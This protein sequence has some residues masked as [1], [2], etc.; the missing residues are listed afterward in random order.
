MRI[1]QEAD[2]ALRIVYYLAST[3]DFVDAKTIAEVTGTPERFTLKILRKLLVAGF[4]TSHKGVGGGYS[5]AADPKSL[6]MKDVIELID[7][8]VAISRCADPEHICSRVGEC[9]GECTFHCIFN[10]INS[11]LADRLASVSIDMVSSGEYT[12]EEILKNI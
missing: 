11:I 9:K 2:Y 4:L 5:M 1:T 12:T 10:R 8:P 7:G 6:S 3:E